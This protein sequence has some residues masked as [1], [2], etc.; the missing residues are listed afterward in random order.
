MRF[1]LSPRGVFITGEDAQ[2]LF[3]RMVKAVPTLMIGV[4]EGDSILRDLAKILNWAD[5]SSGKKTQSMKPYFECFRG[6]DVK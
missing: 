6:L 3:A 2:S 5:E 4:E 1:G